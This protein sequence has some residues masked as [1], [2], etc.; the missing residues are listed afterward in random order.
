MSISDFA[1]KT[2]PAKPETSS[3]MSDVLTAMLDRIE[4]VENISTEKLNILIYSMPGVG[5]TSFLGTIP[6]QF[7]LNTEGSG[8]V[9]LKAMPTK[10]GPVAENIAT[11]PYSSFQ[12]MENMVKEFQND[13]P[14]LKKFTTFTVDT[15]SNLH[16]KGLAEVTDRENRKAPNLVNRYVAETEHHGENNEHIRR[17]VDSLRD[18]D[19]NVVLTAHARF[20]EPKNRPAQTWPDFSVKLSNT[21][22]GMMDIVAYMGVKRVDDENKIFM[23]MHATPGIVA[24]NR[25]GITESI[26]DPTWEKLQ[27]LING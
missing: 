8:I 6:N 5:K 10:L 15:I 7:L 9:S 24:K 23:Q 19:R 13:P 11:I 17:I 21:I 16:K 1:G 3:N 25:F 20:E 4:P 26:I 22:A 12:G 27:E 14:E 18:L 2:E